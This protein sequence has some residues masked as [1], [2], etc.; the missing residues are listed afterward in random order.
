[1][2]AE[3]Y[4]MQRNCVEKVLNEDVNINESSAFTFTIQYLAPSYFSHTSTQN[5]RVFYLLPQSISYVSVWDSMPSEICEDNIYNTK[6]HKE[7][8]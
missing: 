3:E 4:N 5:G 7:K 1:M 2:Y 6:R 8:V